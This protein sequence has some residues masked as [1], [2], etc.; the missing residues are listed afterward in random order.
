LD[1]S[2]LGGQRVSLSGYQSSTQ[3][4]GGI[5]F[6]DLGGRRVNLAQ[7]AQDKPELPGFSQRWAEGMGI[8]VTQEEEDAMREE[9]K[10]KWYDFVA[11]GWGR[12]LKML[13]GVGKNAYEHAK[14]AA[15]EAVTS[16]GNISKGEAIAP[17][18]VRAGESYVENQIKS[19]PGGEQ[20]WNFGG[21]VADKNWRGAAGGTTAAFLQALLMDAI[22]GERP[23]APKALTPSVPP[24]IPAEEVAVTPR[25]VADTPGQPFGKYERESSAPA[26]TLPEPQRGRGTGSA[27]EVAPPRTIERPQLPAFTGKASGVFA[28][29]K[30]PGPAVPFESGPRTGARSP[31]HQADGHVETQAA[32]TYEG[33]R[34]NGRSSIS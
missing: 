9:M 32:F 18:L 24:T 19:V 10:P 28:P 14:E 4:G 15:N 3:S 30:P 20:L 17:N 6:R 34:N 29:T 26:L 7:T 13:Y 22:G 27:K 8:P 5:D 2:D 12:G 11:P 33:E 31:F 23:S 21:D 25:P 1:F 16:A